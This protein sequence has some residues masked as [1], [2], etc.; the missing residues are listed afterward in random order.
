MITKHTDRQFEEELQ[1]LKEEILKAG[2]IVEEMMVRSLNALVKRNSSEAKQVIEQDP[3]VDQ[4]QIRIDDF[5]LKILA[6]RQPAASDLRFIAIGMR[7]STDL[8]RIGDLA[9][10]IAE[11]ILKLN[12]EPQLKPYIDLPKLFKR[13]HAMLKKALDAF[14]E[15]EVAK[16]RE[17]CESDNEVDLLCAQ[18]SSEL[19]EIAKKDPEAL[20]RALSLIFISRHLE[21][22]AD[23]ATNIAEEAIFMVS[24]E[25]IRHGQK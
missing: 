9:V 3:E 5:C 20:G 21:R 23:H 10:N 13:A 16:A 8:E 14:V 18:I 17:V 2:G 11:E 1:K 12:E 4:L 6:L 22:V 24:G 15:R 25:D 7:I 19:M